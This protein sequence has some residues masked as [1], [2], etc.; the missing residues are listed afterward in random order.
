MRERGVPHANGR[1]LKAHSHPL[2]RCDDA[3]VGKIPAPEALE[4]QTHHHRVEAALSVWRR[5]LSLRPAIFQ[6]FQ[7]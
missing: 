5:V 4:A 2:I 6:N 7:N 3:V 1:L